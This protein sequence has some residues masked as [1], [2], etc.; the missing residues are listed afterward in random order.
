MVLAVGTSLGRSVLILFQVDGKRDFLVA[1]TSIAGC[2]II[3]LDERGKE[4][5]YNSN[6]SGNTKTWIH[7]EIWK[8][9]K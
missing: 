1:G 8:Y 2:Y 4:A 7:W 5:Q 6:N 9:I 3:A